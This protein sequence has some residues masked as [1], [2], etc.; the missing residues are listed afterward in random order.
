MSDILSFYSIKKYYKG[1]G[2]KVVKALNGVTFSVENES[3]LSVIGESGSGKTTLAMIASFLEEPTEGYL[4]FKNKIIDKSQSKKALWREIQLVF[5]DPGRSLNPKRSVEFLLKEPL[6][7]YSI[8]HQKEMEKKID[9]LL[10]LFELPEYLKK[11]KADELSGGEKQRIAIAR[12]LSVSPSLLILDEPFSFI[13]PLVKKQTLSVLI[14]Y[15]KKNR[16]SWIFINHDL[17]SIGSFSDY[18]IILYKGL[19]ME[20]GKAEII[21]NPLHPYTNFLLSPTLRE[22]GEISPDK[23]CPF[24]SKCNFKLDLCKYFCPELKFTNKRYVRC[25][26]Y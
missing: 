26:L 23:G 22:G 16:M 24:F 25:H 20:S 10:E 2:S 4:Y 5:Q 8:C 13:D 11:R 9:Y 17:Q 15:K 12:A 7:N 19:I 18:V 6:L 3:I 14:D 21:E 1:A